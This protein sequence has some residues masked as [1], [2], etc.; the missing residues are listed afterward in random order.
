MVRA[1]SGVREHSVISVKKAD[2]VFHS[3]LYS[4]GLVNRSDTM[5]ISRRIQSLHKGLLA[6]LAITALLHGVAIAHPDPDPHPHVLQTKSATFL[7]D[8]GFQSPAS[9]QSVSSG[10]PNIEQG[11]VGSGSS[12]EILHTV[13]RDRSGLRGI[14]YEVR[15]LQNQASGSASV[16]AQ[17]GII[18]W[19]RANSF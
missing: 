3:A 15:I 9:V 10:C 5:A 7:R 2:V 1:S 12:V 8:C 17:R 18:G 16:N 19:L 14:W 13:E 6:G 4:F 11:L